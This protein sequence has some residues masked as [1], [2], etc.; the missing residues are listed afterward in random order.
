V[1]VYCRIAMDQLRLKCYYR[2]RL[3]Q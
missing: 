2:Y 3:A 1:A